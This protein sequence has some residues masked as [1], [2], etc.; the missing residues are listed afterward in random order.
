MLTAA[1]LC[2]FVRVCACLCVF[3]RVCACLRVFVRVCACS[4]IAQETAGR[5]SYVGIGISI[6]L[7]LSEA[8]VAVIA[9]SHGIAAVTWLFFL[10]WLSGVKL[11]I[12]VIKYIPQV[13]MNY[14]RKSTEGWSIGNVLLDFTGGLLSIIQLMLDGYIS[15]MRCDAL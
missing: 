15:G 9:V 4:T 13:Y 6:G 14:K 11:S 2:M 3:V 10:Y 8:L 7:V 1:C 12:S 5:V